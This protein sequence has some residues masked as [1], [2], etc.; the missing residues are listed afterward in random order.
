MI[1]ALTFIGLSVLLFVTWDLYINAE[2]EMKLVKLIKANYTGEPKR[3]SERTL[4]R[5]L[6]TPKA[7]RGEVHWLSSATYR[8]KWISAYSWGDGS[9]GH[10]Q[11]EEF[12]S[13]EQ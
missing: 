9:E 1:I 5:F 11:D 2:Q 13:D 7:I 8:Q 4:K 10:W 3:G 6:W 12:I